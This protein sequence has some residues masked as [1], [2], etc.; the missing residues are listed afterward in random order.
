MA[1][2][3]TRSGKHISPFPEEFQLEGYSFRDKKT[4]L[5]FLQKD[6]L[7][8]TLLLEA[9]KHIQKYFPGTSKPIL[10]VIVDIE[11]EQDVNLAVCIPISIEPEEAIQRLKNLSMDWW[12]NA[13]SKTQGAV[14]LDLEYQ[15]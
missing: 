1:P 2:T 9:P 5:Q 7:L 6:P 8:V 10:E 13:K 4:V 11:N 12:L 14:Y 3:S 15:A